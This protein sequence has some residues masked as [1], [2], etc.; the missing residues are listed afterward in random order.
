MLG[1]RLDCAT[2]QPIHRKMFVYA[3]DEEAGAMHFRYNFV[4]TL[5]SVARLPLWP[6]NRHHLSDL[7]DV[8]AST[9]VCIYPC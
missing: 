2:A 4:S 6:N 5:A 3:V 1:L 7:R 8:S 9:L